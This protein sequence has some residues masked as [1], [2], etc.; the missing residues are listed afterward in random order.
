MF[1]K[2]E[3]S[4]IKMR[5]QHDGIG[6]SSTSIPLTDGKL[7]DYL[8]VEY[9]R[10]GGLYIERIIDNEIHL[11][12]SK[13]KDYDDTEDKIDEIKDI[14]KDYVKERAIE[15]DAY[16][17]FAKGELKGVFGKYYNAGFK[18]S[19][20]LRNGYSKEDIEIKEIK[21]ESFEDVL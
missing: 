3:K 17:V 4:I 9:R 10:H 20:L 13:T 2:N 7:F 21:I 16:A 11:T 12:T 1:K 18:E 14:I 6:G 5:Y 8:E 15:M 19:R